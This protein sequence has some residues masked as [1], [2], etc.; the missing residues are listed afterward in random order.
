MFSS[1]D[2]SI[3]GIH[4]AIWW[5]EEIG[6]QAKTFLDYIIYPLLVITLF[7]IILFAYVVTFIPEGGFLGQWEITKEHARFILFVSNMVNG[8]V[9]IAV[10]ATIWKLR[11]PRFLRYQQSALRIVERLKKEKMIDETKERQMLDTISLNLTPCTDPA[12]RKECEEGR[13]RAS[14]ALAKICG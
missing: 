10:L 1:V 9:S 12:R 14:V 7:S 13:L 11:T 6:K 3:S 5:Q 2:E 4:D 8:G